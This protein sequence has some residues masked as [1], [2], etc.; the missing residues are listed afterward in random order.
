MVAVEGDIAQ[1]LAVARVGPGRLVVGAEVAL[2]AD[3]GGGKGPIGRRL[4]TPG[5]RVRALE[6]ARA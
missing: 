6:E 3:A 4:D 1:G 2:L 5:N